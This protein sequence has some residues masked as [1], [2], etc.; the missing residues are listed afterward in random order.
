MKKIYSVLLI[1]VLLSGCGYQYERG[2]DRESAGTLQQKRDVLLK[3][4]PFTVNN[5]HPGD[6]SNVYEARR[7]YIG[8]G[9]ESDEFL[10][11]LISQCYNSTSDLCAYDYYVNAANAENEKIIAEQT[12][13]ANEYKQQAIS[14]RSKK[15][16]VKKGDL[17]YCKVAF[18]PSLERTDSGIRVGVKDNIDTVGFIFSNGYKLISPV[19]K[20]VDEA[21]GIRAGQTDDKAIT[22]IASYDGN[23]YSIDT[24]NNYILRQFSRGIIIDTEQTE[25]AGRIDAYDCTKG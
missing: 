7:N 25:H 6:P 16:P 12:K 19:L 8:H 5:R 20:V 2:R 15:L 22:V 13:V 9:E 23:S 11:G 24:Y 17:F 10:S 1:S 4:T 14:E 3:W 21:S 18:N